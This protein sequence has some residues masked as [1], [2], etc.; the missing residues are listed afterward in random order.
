MHISYDVA[1][2]FPAQ[3][4]CRDRHMNDSCVPVWLQHKPLLQGQGKVKGQMCGLSGLWTAA[5]MWVL[6]HALKLAASISCLLL[7][8]RMWVKI[9]GICM[10]R[11]HRAEQGEMRSNKTHQA[12]VTG[13]AEREPCRKMGQLFQTEQAND[14][15][16][17]KPRSSIQSPAPL[18][19]H[20]QSLRRAHSPQPGRH[21]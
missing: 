10:L 13:E 1:F 14:F 6:P 20:Q 11:A 18:C 16:P 3:C 17:K 9:Q 5:Q 19:S 8:L 4:V 15:R 7:P 12:G 21:L 2:C